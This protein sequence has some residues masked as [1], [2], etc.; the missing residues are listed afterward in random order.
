MNC[1]I[2]ERLTLHGT[3][4]EPRPGRAMNQYTATPWDTRTYDAA[5]NLRTG[6]DVAPA[7]SGGRSLGYDALGRLVRYQGEQRG[8][9]VLVETFSDE[10]LTGWTPWSGSWEK[11]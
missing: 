4:L 10:D 3:V 11:G 6:V 9:A 5:G 7:L 1:V 2:E 8:P